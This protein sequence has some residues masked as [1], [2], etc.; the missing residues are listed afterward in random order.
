MNYMPFLAGVL[1]GVIARGQGIDK[2]AKKK[3]LGA[4]RQRIHYRTRI[5]MK[6]SEKDHNERSKER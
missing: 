4:M 3:V 1:S 6:G 5:L 2:S